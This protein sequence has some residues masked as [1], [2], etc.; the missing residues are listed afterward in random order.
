MCTALSGQCRSKLVL[1][2]QA[3]CRSV[4]TSL[5]HPLRVCLLKLPLVFAVVRYYYCLPYAAVNMSLLCRFVDS[6]LR[7]CFL[8]L[9]CEIGECVLFFLLSYG[10]GYLL[11]VMVSCLFYSC[12]RVCD[13]SV[14]SM[15]HWRC[16]GV[17]FTAYPVKS[18][19]FAM[20]V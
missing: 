11:C 13:F 10:C 19:H 7:E 17:T 2:R 20:L 18:L 1:S 4:C 8:L 15:R 5:Y 12:F 3:F 9:F 6:V 14:Q 16:M